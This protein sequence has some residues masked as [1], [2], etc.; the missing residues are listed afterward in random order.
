[1]AYYK[2]LFE[3]SFK[4]GIMLQLT[5]RADSKASAADIAVAIEIV[6]AYLTDDTAAKLSA[7]YEQEL[8]AEIIRAAAVVD[9]G[10]TNQKR[11]AD[12]ELELEVFLPDWKASKHVY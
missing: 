8:G 9:H 10:T 11:K 5:Q 2:Q 6:S 12:W 4:I 7:A 3:S 1:M